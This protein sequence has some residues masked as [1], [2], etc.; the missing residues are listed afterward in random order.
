MLLSLLPENLLD[1]A[2]LFLNFAGDLFAGV[3][4]M[5]KGIFC[6]PATNGTPKQLWPA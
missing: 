6:R 3:C 5:A 4:P 1:L 2:G